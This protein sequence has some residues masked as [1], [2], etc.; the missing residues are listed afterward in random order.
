[1][2][3]VEFVSRERKYISVSR[4]GIV[5]IWNMNGR[6]QKTIDTKA[7]S[8][9][10]AWVSDAICLSDQGKLAILCDDR[11]YART[12]FFFIY[13]HAQAVRLRR[14]V[15]EGASVGHHWANGGF[16]ALAH[17]FDAL[18]NALATGHDALGHHLAAL[19]DAG[20]VL[21]A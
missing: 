16:T 3:K 15:V 20:E 13:N 14:A 8:G 9:T 18:R 21:T 17:R 1:M 12:Y 4:D 11:K 2:R 5:C 10:T 19:C 7:L 6:L